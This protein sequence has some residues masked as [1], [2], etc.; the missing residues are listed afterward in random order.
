[1]RDVWEALADCAARTGRPL[2]EAARHHVLEGLLR[3]VAR[4][5]QPEGFVLRGGML[6]RLWA[7][8]APRPA[9]DLDFVGIFPHGLEETVRRFAPALAD[10]DLADGVLIDAAAF[11]A[12][13]IWE[14]SDF[15]GVRLTVR[16]GLGAADRDVQIDIGFGDPLVPLPQL[17]DY[18]TIIPG[19]P[20]RLWCCRPETMAG[21][22]LHGLAEKGERLWRPKD[23]YDLLLIGE[24]VELKVPEL[25][26]A[27][28]VAFTSRGFRAEQAPAV[29]AD[30][31]WW[32]SKTSLFRW[33]DF[34]RRAEGLDVP[35]D[36]AEVV[37]RVTARLRP[38]LELLPT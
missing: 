17:V 20:P 23:L 37:A 18:P 16:V 38:A 2:G 19:A 3:R 8:P 24:R 21:W 25:A 29:L 35:E 12:R 15:P 30:A 22:K 27:I 31:A 33:A 10:R 11:R 32:A 34:R 6:T 7:A 14:D 36:L 13:A 4:L 28:A 1:M 26:Q 5:P 9:Q